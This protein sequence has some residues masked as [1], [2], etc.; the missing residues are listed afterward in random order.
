MKIDRAIANIIV[1]PKAYANPARIDGAFSE[2]RRDAPFALAEPDG[3]D[4][5]WVVTKHADLLEVERQAAIFANGAG[6]NNLLMRDAIDLARTVT[7]GDPNLIR[8]LVTVDGKIHKDLRG[9]AFP[10]FTPKAIKGAEEIVRSIADQFIDDMLAN[11][12]HCD[13]ARDVA[14]FYPLRVIMTLL[15]I[16]KEDEPYL[17]RLTQQL[18]GNTD[19]ELSRSGQAENGAIAMETLAKVMAD[20]EAYFDE[21]TMKLR[22]TPADNICSLIANAMIDGAYLGRRELMGYYIIAATAGHD[23]TSNT[24]AMAMWALAER[25]QLLKDLKRDPDLLAPFIEESIRWTTPIKTFMRTA[26]ENGEVNGKKVAQGDWVMLSYHSANRDE[27]VFA[28]P[29]EFRIDRPAAAKHVAFG[30]GPHVCLGQHLAR[31]EMR[32]FW[33]QLLPRISSVNL[34]GTPTLTESNF[35]VGPKTVPLEFR[36][37]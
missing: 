6:C 1:D 25:P 17:L 12:P 26:V 11:G 37:A 13:F 35:V 21:V 8:T 3:Y 10:H 9:I 34:T 28:D 23:T 36:V 7:G 16:P 19:P 20:F 33:E 18:L 14:F 32:V 30:S 27:D 29:F 5:F 2:L 24:T 31:L 15:G 22:Q 4:P